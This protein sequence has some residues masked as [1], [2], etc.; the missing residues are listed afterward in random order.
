MIR[1][2]LPAL[3]LLIAPL[4]L[5]A[6]EEKFDAAAR[7][8]AVAP[9]FG[10]QAFAVVHVDLTKL[11]LDAIQAVLAKMLPADDLKDLERSKPETKKKLQEIIDAG[12]KDFYVV[13]TLVA[14]P[15]R[16]PFFLDLPNAPPGPLEPVL[17]K[18]DLAGKSAQRVGDAALIGDENILKAVVQAKSDVA[19][20]PELTAAF[21]GAGDTDLQAVV[22]PPTYMRRII[23]ETMPQLPEQVGGGSSK[24]L[25][26]GIRWAAVGVAFPP[27]LG[28]K[29]TV[30]SD[31]PEAAKAL[32]A[33][34]N[35]VLG[36]VAKLPDARQE[37]P[38]IEKITTLLAPQQQG[39]QLTLQFDEQGEK[40]K[41]LLDAVQVPL[42]QARSTARR[43]QSMN[44][45]KQIGLGM[46]MAADQAKGVFPSP[47][48][49]TADGKPL[50]SW[51]VHHLPF[52]GQDELYKRFK[53]DEPWDSPAN[54]KLI[55]QMPVFYRSPASK[56]AREEGKT[57]YVLPTGEGTMFAR[58]EGMKIA[59][60][61]DGTSNTIMALEVNDDAAVVWTKPEDW[62]FNPKQP[63][64]NLGGLY[65]GGFIALYADG[66]V[67]FLSLP[68]AKEKLPALLSPTGGEVVQ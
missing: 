7:A 37:V 12:V 27:K 55:A 31:S 57:N 50:L 4:V 58:R 34:W 3:M 59:G 67:R 29:L 11:D 18:L 9:F 28:A 1:P 65:E 15:Q 20:I 46:H 23:E 66:S 22:V 68:E 41:L 13:F 32:M 19:R 48:S 30:Q 6:A 56:L 43:A 10:E 38:N 17:A 35:E 45:L 42:R 49:R 14:A 36:I 63:L 61:T 33:K 54:K 25:T 40:G 53:L 26:E 44:N 5:H 62:E 60:I 52:L 24:I 39:N 64:A 21:A 47:A 2:I 8:K 16:E 51:R